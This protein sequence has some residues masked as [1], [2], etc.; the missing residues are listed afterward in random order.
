[1]KSIFLQ[2]WAKKITQLTFSKS[3]N[4]FYK[5]KPHILKIMEGLSFRDTQI[6]NWQTWQLSFHLKN[7]IHL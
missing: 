2:I 7:F 1:M 3:Y 4:I 5:H 6:E